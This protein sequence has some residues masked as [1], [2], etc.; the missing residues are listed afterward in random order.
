MAMFAP[1]A[2]EAGSL[3]TPALM[4]GLESVGGS[5]VG[6]EAMAGL[7]KLANVGMFHFGHHVSPSKLLEKLVNKGSKALVDPV[8]FQNILEKGGKAMGTV[9]QGGQHLANVL[10]KHNLI[11]HE[12]SAKWRSN[13]GRFDHGFH[14]AL[15][16]LGKVHSGLMPFLQRN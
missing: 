10:E 6:K 14:R 2:L 8:K 9:T 3:L 11:G 4:S 16:K 5:L 12:K 7:K 1:L 13:L 15:G